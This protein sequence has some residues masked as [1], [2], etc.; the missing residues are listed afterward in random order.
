MAD[1]D[2]QPTGSEPTGSESAGSES[3]GS[4]SAGSEPAGSTPAKR[5]G[6]R[7]IVLAIVVAVLALGGIAAAVI[8]NRDDGRSYDTAQ[9]G[10]MHQ[11]CQQWS[12]SYQGGD[13][14]GDG[15]CTSMTDWMDDRMGQRRGGMMMGPMMWQ[16][17][18]SMRATCQEWMADDPPADSSG[19]RAEW[20]DQM[21][22]WMSDHMGDWD[23]WM[24]DGPRMG[25]S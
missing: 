18:D 16:D 7:W 5:P 14:P 19:G 2:G 8:A 24:G 4:E 3:A 10:R 13:G 6:L 21:V 20:C 17:P 15:W 12:E 25:G 11:G 9:I 23:R 1:H 22:D